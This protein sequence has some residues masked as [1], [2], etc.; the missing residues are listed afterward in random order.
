MEIGYAVLLFAHAPSP[1]YVE[2]T[3]GPDMATPDEWTAFDETG[4][5]SFALNVANK[6]RRIDLVAGNGP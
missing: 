3:A 4:P 6:R 5:S 2:A 1:F